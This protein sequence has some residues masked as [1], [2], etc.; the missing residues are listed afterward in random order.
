MF[1]DELYTWTALYMNSRY[2]YVNLTWRKL[3][4]HDF[5]LLYYSISLN[6]KF[7]RSCIKKKHFYNNSQLQLF[8]LIDVTKT[9]SR[10]SNVN[11]RF[12]RAPVAET[13]LD[14]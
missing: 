8:S 12:N 13:E 2:M 9:H 10:N 4:Y 1:E 14:L 11:Y 7:W 3:F 6:K 5:N